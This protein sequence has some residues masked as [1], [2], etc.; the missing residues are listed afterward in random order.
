[1][2]ADRKDQ[3]FAESLL[4]FNTV[5][6][7]GTYV[8][9]KLG[10]AG[11]DSF[12][13]VGLRYAIAAALCAGWV[14]ATR[15]PLAPHLRAG[16]ILGFFLFLGIG[17]QTRGLL[18][19]SAAKSGFITGMFVVFTPFLH[20]L[21]NARRPGV[22][23][24]ASIALILVG[25]FMLTRPGDTKSAYDGFN[26]G[27]FLTVLSSLG[28]S[29]YIV[30]VDRYARR[31]PAPSLVFLQMVATALFGFATALAL[32]ETAVAPGPAAL[33]SLAYLALPGTLLM[34][35]IQTRYQ[36]RSDPVRAAIIFSLEPVFAALAA[37]FFL[38]EGLGRRGM[39][40]GAIMLAGVMLSE[41]YK[42]I[43]PRRN[44]PRRAS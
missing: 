25:L 33:W 41:V 17:F 20:W 27:D 30:Y 36:T 29:F 16:L 32:G 44:A 39:I 7:G 11:F 28:F 12:M 43:A 13:L 3:F 1:M 4:A 15:S 35:F 38:D 21:I 14:L 5:V 24:Y 9:I 23:N 22:E 19:T 26:L 34:V 40:G 18:Y 8:A 37:W 10:L 42:V 31:A 2:T 6:W